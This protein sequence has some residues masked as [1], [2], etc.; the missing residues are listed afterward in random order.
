MTG[1]SGSYSQDAH[2]VVVQRAE[3]IPN[4]KPLGGHTGD[5]GNTHD[6]RDNLGDSLDKAS[7]LRSASVCQVPADI[8]PVPTMCET[9]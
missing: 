1:P 9:L 6:N 5:A 7:R 2:D 8:H 4:T 3:R